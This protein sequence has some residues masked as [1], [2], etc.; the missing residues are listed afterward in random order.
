MSL[1][2]TPAQP[3]SFNPDV[4][5]TI[6]ARG[7]TGRP[8]SPAFAS[9]RPQR[10][11]TRE[12]KIE[13]DRRQADLREQIEKETKIKVGS[14]NLLEALNAKKS[15]QTREQRIQVESELSLTNRKIAQLRFHL[16]AEIERSRE[17]SPSKLT[18]LF[19]NAPLRSPSQ[20]EDDNP[21]EEETESP[22]FLLAELLQALEAEGHAAEYYV[23][24]ANSLAE[25]LQR[26]STLK[27]DLVWSIFG[28]RMQA[29]LLSDSRE[30]VAASYRVL[31]HSITDRRSI[32]VIRSLQTD[33]FVILS[34]VKQSKASVE[35]E[36][37]LKLI[38]A[39][40]DVK[41]GTK[42]IPKGIVRVIAAVAHHSDDRMR[43]ICTLTLAEMIIRD[44][45]LVISAGGLS[46][47][48]E[49]FA[50]R[51]YQSSDGLIHAFLYLSDMPFRRKHMSAGYELDSPFAA[52]TDGTLTANE[53]TL[54]AN[55][56][57]IAMLFKSWVGLFMLSRNRFAAV[58]SLLASMQMPSTLIRD[59][60]LELVNDI[61]RIKSPS[62]STSFLAGRRLTT[63]GRVVALK[64]PDAEQP[65]GDEKNELVNHFIAATLAVLVHSNLLDM[66]LYSIQ[67]EEDG[68]VKRK[69]T[70]LLG[71]VLNL[72]HDLLPSDWSL[73][74]QVL[75]ALFQSA[76]VLKHDDRHIASST[77]YQIDSVNRTLHRTGKAIGS[78][79]SVQTPATRPIRTLSDISKS[80]LTPQIDE[81]HF[82]AAINETGVLASVKWSTSWR[83]D[84]ILKI[85]E[86]P[87]MN[88]KRLEEAIKMSKFVKRL[89]SFF[90]PFKYR[91][92]EI[93]NT[94]PN[95]RYVRIGCS[96]MRT[97]LAN[98]EGINYL[99][100]DKLL[101]QVAECL[102]QVDR[103]S[104]LTSTAPLF[105]AERLKDT[106]SG[107]YFAVL[108]VL[109]G[110][111]MGLLM[112]DRWRMYNMFY[113]IV[114][115]LDR[116]DLIKALL[117][118]LDYTLDSPV[119]VILSKAMTSCSLEV[120]VF[121]TRLLRKYA[122][123]RSKSSVSEDVSE[124]AQWAIQLLVTQLYDPE[125]EVCEIA[126]KILEETCND[127][128]SLEFVVQ[129]RPA[130][131]HLGEIGAPL[132]LRFL[133]TSVGYHYLDGLD[134]ISQE[135]DDWFL[136][137]ND[138]YVTL[139]EASLAKVSTGA[140]ERLATHP[141][142]DDLPET[143]TSGSAPPHF[144]RE[145]TRTAEGCE[146]L[147]QKGH[148]AE[149]V[150]VIREQG[151]ETSDPET[152]LKVKGA[153]WAV[154]N[155]GSMEFG[156]PLLESSDAVELIVHIAEHSEVL[157]MRGTAFFVLGLISRSV[158]GQEILAEHGW[159]S[160]IDEMGNTRGICLP[161]DL[162]SLF[163]LPPAP[164]E[165]PFPEEPSE[166]D[167]ADRASIKA[168]LQDDNPTN[169]EILRLVNDLSNSV[170]TKSRASELHAIK[171]KKV[172]GFQSTE[173]FKK[174]MRV[175]EQ[176]HYR[177]PVLRFVIDL[178]DR[179]VLRKIV[180]EDSESEEEGDNTIVQGSWPL[181]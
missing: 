59:I 53:E 127:E 133:S 136:G 102:A 125:V 109:S 171:A 28:T 15:K 24:R 154:G 42:E 26:N 152:M 58:K 150:T 77:I 60:V 78:S 132:L 39:F 144:Y 9:F 82:R 98:Q 68:N 134:Y 74:M 123:Q 85:V 92:C 22:T 79:G 93:R 6:I 32:S 126:I 145:L 44:P 65:M 100:E 160:S 89:M 69:A 122:T 140:Q 130:L 141:E 179:N 91:F 83:W 88:P 137:R 113:H 35:R 57:V 10:L 147:N 95:Q 20:H 166:E 105:S 101:R 169:A 177:L 131:D 5:S 64:D 162:Y 43:G 175:L 17:P 62:W 174:V 66:L 142:Q 128:A 56:S 143:H 129:C 168:A 25:L 47:L 148:F 52:F 27:Y 120:Q 124:S 114:E 139:V 72:A 90:R 41:E 33:Y 96:L 51:E 157:S 34:L 81:A 99:V 119:R 7:D 138:D 146:L 107:G 104:G 54:K 103:L 172:P 151:M 180:L 4:K 163:A 165:S 50:E 75:P 118:A 111:A 3:G 31:R 115:L 135:M 67:N 121:A 1:A 12:D 48:S 178:F 18:Q 84:L 155:I 37:A 110:S 30:V 156:A 40:V 2:L 21:L 23:E 19:K 86:G 73:K 76:A 149:F 94:K 173:L 108:G 153:L 117:G 164:P 112:F 116:D 14:E 13:S 29:L 38:R 97:L 158:H 45:A 71:E 63:Y 16:N 36:Q 159:D 11:D 167:Q 87:L 161:T 106:L 181:P 46:V 49:A 55:A 61:L 8:D 176:H 170:L 70:L 80:E